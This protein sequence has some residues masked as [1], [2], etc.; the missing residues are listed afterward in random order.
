MHSTR[1]GTFIFFA[2]AYV[3]N[4]ELKYIK[5]DRDVKISLIQQKDI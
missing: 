2:A 4:T 5:V 3:N 1:M